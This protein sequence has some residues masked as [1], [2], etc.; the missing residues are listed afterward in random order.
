[1]KDLYEILGVDKNADDKAIQQAFRKLAKKYHPDVNPDNPEAE[2][3]FKEVGQAYAIL[4]DPEKKRHYDSG[5]MDERGD[6]RHSNFDHFG[7]F[8][9]AAYHTFFDP[10]GQ[11][12]INEP[13]KTSPNTDI[14]STLVLNPEQSFEDQEVQVQYNRLR[15]C[16]DCN[17]DGGKEGKTTCP[18]CNGTK[19]AKRQFNQHTI[20]VTPCERCQQRGFIFNQICDS[21]KGFGIRE[22]SSTYTV[23]V[24]VGSCFKKLRV[25]GG[26]NQLN[27]N[28]DPGDLLIV[29]IVPNPHKGFQ[30]SNDG[31]VYM[32]LGIDP[33]EALLGV[34][35]KVVDIKGENVTVQV[36]SGSREK[37][38]LRI[39]GHGLMTSKTTRGTFAVVLKYDYSTTLSDEQKGILLEYLS[40]KKEKEASK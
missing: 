11:M 26:G 40:I 27:P 13:R 9:N 15:F 28:F 37:Q 21:C 38:I 10:F 4:G 25:A 31:T 22:E 19:Q 33:V 2:E 5:Q 8:Q 1:M 36:P 32:E 3:K 14:E 34:E 24:P 30:F 18:D 16:S 35:K 39:P 20:V 7:G 12:H 17:G 29:I 23:K 6:V